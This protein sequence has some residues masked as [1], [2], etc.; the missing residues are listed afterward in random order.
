MNANLKFYGIT[1]GQ[2]LNQVEKFSIKDLDNFINFIN[3][4]AGNTSINTLK[5]DAEK[6]GFSDR[7]IHGEM[8]IARVL[9][10]I[11]TIL[12]CESAFLFEVPDKIRNQNIH[13]LGE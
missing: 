9:K 6:R 1:K 4:S 2:A 7:V 3:S 12:P 5:Y 13:I 8:I 11:G 10:H